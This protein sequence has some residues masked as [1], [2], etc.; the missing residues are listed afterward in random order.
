LNKTPLFRRRHTATTARPFWP[1]A[2][3][4]V[5]TFQNIFFFF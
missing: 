3:H 4:R 2:K 5:S 1:P